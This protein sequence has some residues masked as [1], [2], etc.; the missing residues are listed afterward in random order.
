MH[1]VTF[2]SYKG[3][4]GRT[5]ALANVAYLLAEAGKRVLVVDFDLEA[6]GLATYDAFSEGRGRPGLVEYVKAYRETDE[7]PEVEDYLTRCD[8]DGTNIWL[9]SAGRSGTAQYASDFNSIDWRDLYDNQ[10]GFLLME[11]M[12]GQWARFD[13]RGFDYVLI[14]SRTGHT[15]IGGICTRQLPDA[16]VILFVPTDQNIDGLVPIVRS[17]RK[18]AAPVRERPARL[19]FCPS[20]VP[21]SDD[22]EEILVRRLA[23]ASRRLE[24][25]EPAVVVNHFDSIELLDQPIFARRHKQ[26]RLARQMRQL[27]AAIIRDNLEDREGAIASVRELPDRYRMAKSCNDRSELD[28]IS[29]IAAQIRRLHPKDGEIA[30]G[31]AQLANAMTRSDDE[32]SALDVM[33]ETGTSVGSALV[34]RAVLRAPL[35]RAA[36]VADLRRAVVEERSTVFELIPALDFIRR[37]APD[38]LPG[39]LRSAAA[40]PRIDPAGK[41]QILL[42]ML[43]TDGDIAAARELTQEALR[44]APAYERGPLLNVYV[45]T[46]IGV[47]D[48]DQAMSEITSDRTRL[49]AEGSV[50]DT[51]NYLIAEWGALGRSSPDIAKAVLLKRSELQRP[52]DANSL[53]CFAICQS[54]LGDAAGFAAD[55][56]ESRAKTGTHETWFDCWRWRHVAT[57]TM[58]ADLDDMERAA[59]RQNVARPPFLDSFGPR[60]RP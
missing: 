38:L 13:G 14:D 4:V 55:L 46:L 10:D 37:L 17:I 30:K 41:A 57:D 60:R 45:L 39:I 32:L 34:Q 9:M 56:S 15:D 6:P 44:V 29:A 7:S 48:F 40:N 36:A 58:Q 26:T 31:L 43:T 53:Q 51:F 42:R 49:I 23:D 21:I 8:F 52:P 20:N 12:K 11:D 35:D 59:A 25:R 5:M 27:A 1:V 22:Q 54:I 50:S 19:H 47:G 24:Y 2:Y 28:D 16:V 3:G 18:E 33:I